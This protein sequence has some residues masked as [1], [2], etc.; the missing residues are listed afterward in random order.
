MA[1]IWAEQWLAV[2]PVYEWNA[3]I[4]IG[5]LIAADVATWS[6]GETSR[7]STIRDLDAPPALQYFFSVMQFH[8]TAGCLV[9]VRR[10][11]TQFIYVWII[12]FTAFL[13]TLR[14]KNLAPHN[15][16]VRIYGA[17]LTFGFVIATK[18]ALSASSWALV[19][20]VANT[21]AVGRLGCRINKYVLWL[22][23]ALFC[24][25]AR[26]TVSGSDGLGHLAQIWPF[27]WALS[28]VGVLLVGKAKLDRAAAEEAKTR[29]EETAKAQ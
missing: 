7:S 27:T 1:L 2:A 5:T 13:M 9:G 10:F 16:L 4:V 20:T 17:M 11:S 12:Q 14:R 23:M 6:V 18:D 21:A 8:A 19:N 24:T 15:S 25:F 3:A 29:L 28:V 26:K 22:V